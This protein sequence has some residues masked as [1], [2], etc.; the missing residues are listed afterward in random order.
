[1]AGRHF[2]LNLCLLQFTHSW[3]V[4]VSIPLLSE[5]NFPF[6][7]GLEQANIFVDPWDKL[8]TPNSISLPHY[9]YLKLCN[10]LNWF[11]LW[12]SK[13]LHDSCKVLTAALL[14]FLLQTV[15]MRVPH[16]CISCIAPTFTI[17]WPT[18]QDFLIS[19][20]MEQSTLSRDFFL[21]FWRIITRNSNSHS[22]PGIGSGI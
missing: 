7:K 2:Q 4:K 21:R 17:S 19:A 5:I 6:F 16:A 9:S 3:R 14:L 10:S 15:R 13:F 12:T 18:A 8:V 1:M 22:F 11:I 20:F